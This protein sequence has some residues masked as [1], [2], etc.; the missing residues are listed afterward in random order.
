MT[1]DRWEAFGDYNDDNK[2]NEGVKAE[3]ERVVNLLTKLRDSEY[4]EVMT[5]DDVI[6][7]IMEDK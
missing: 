6:S 2:F 5:H 3:R 4:A 1:E 7:I